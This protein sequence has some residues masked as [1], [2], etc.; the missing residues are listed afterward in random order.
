MERVI[1]QSLCTNEGGRAAHLILLVTGSVHRVFVC[2]NN[3]NSH[4]G[5]NF[6]H[7]NRNNNYVMKIKIV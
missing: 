1:F 3:K 2:Y 7:N 6:S 5:N 4:C